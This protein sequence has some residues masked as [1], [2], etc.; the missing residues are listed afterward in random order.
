[1][2]T[3]SDW[4]CVRYNNKDQTLLLQEKCLKYVIFK[5]FFI[6]DTKFFPIYLIIF[7]SVFTVFKALFIFEIKSPL[8]NCTSLIKV[9]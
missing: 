8:G 2:T 1:M 3:H 4:V 9:H 5:N 6:S 7:Q